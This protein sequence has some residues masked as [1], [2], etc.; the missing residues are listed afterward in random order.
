MSMSVAPFI[1]K[2]MPL[3]VGTEQIADAERDRG[4]AQVSVIEPPVDLE[5]NGPLPVADAAAFRQ[6]YRIAHNATLMVSVS[7]LANELKLE[8]LLTAIK[9]AADYPADRRFRLLIVGDGPARGEIE[10]ATHDANHRLRAEVVTLA[11]QLDDPRPAYAAADV[12]LGMGGSALRA[13]AYAKPLIVQGEQGFFAL[14]DRESMSAFLWQGW[15]RLG[16][17]ATE[18]PRLLRAGSANLEGNSEL[19]RELGVMGRRLVDDR[20]SL[21]AAARRQVRLYQIA[22]EAPPSRY[23]LLTSASRTIP[24]Y[25]SYKVVRKFRRVMGHSSTDDFNARPVA[26]RPNYPDATDPGANSIT[27]S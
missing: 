11:G 21:S 4:R 27:K 24:S 26:A 22:S 19:S 13:L 25:S 2:V 18:S 20:Y 9:V 12:V 7:R 3:V 14:L 15:Y 5:H 17:G 6:K 8:G 16:P 23:R 10:R 1:P